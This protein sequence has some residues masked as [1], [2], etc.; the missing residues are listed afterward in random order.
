[1]SSGA[2]V[3]FCVFLEEP[4]DVM[5]FC[6]NSMATKGGT[7]KLIQH[8]IPKSPTRKPEEVPGFWMMGAVV[9]GYL[10]FIWSL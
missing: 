4:L 10:A 2:P 7:M 5:L 1:L 6:R 9:I 8:P 3:F